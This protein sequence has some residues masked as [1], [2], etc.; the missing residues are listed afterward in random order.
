MRQHFE[1]CY[2]GGPHPE[3]ISI[4][5]TL[6]GVQKAFRKRNPHIFDRDYAQRMGMANTGTFDRIYFVD[7]D[8]ERR[9]VAY[10]D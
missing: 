10:G 2:C 1:L 6:N 9:V 5:W 4:H 3:I 8:G 7:S